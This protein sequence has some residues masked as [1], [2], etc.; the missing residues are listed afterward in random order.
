MD[1]IKSDNSNYNMDEELKKLKEMKEFLLSADDFVLNTH[2]LEIG[3]NGV[4]SFC[5]DNKT[6]KVFEGN[7]DGSD[8]REIDYETFIKEYEYYVSHEF[9]QDVPLSF[10]V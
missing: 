5:N 1:I 7:E 4:A 3:T 6:I 9:E 10:K 2:N 8:D